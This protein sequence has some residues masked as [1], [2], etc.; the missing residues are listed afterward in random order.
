MTRPTPP[1]APRPATWRRYLRFWGPNVG[2]DVRDE[3]QFHIDMRTREFEA[4]G[5]DPQDARQA[6][7]ARFGDMAR[8]D[9]ALQ[10]HDRRVD[11]TASVRE[12]ATNVGADVRHAVRA[13]RRAPGFATAAILCLA[14]GT[15]ATA[16][17]FAVVDALLLQPLPVQH[18][19]NLVVIATTSSGM[20]LPGDD[21]YQNYLDIQGTHA[22]LE[23]AAASLTDAFNIRVGNQ[24]DLRTV[25]AVSENYWP[26]LGVRPVLGRTFTPEEARAR[27]PF[28]VIGYRYWQQAF[29]G[30]PDVVGRA[31]SV[32][33]I[34]LTIA[35]VA[36]RDFTGAH[37][38]IIPDLWVPVT[39]LYEIDPSTHDQMQRR[40]GGGF[41]IIGRLQKGVSLATAQSALNVLATHLQH[42]YPADDEGKRF[43][44][45]RELRARPDIAVSD[46][47]PRVAVV[48]MALTT[49]VLLI[50]C[51]NVASL[52][53]ARANGRRTELAVRSALSRR[54]ATSASTRRSRTHRAT[55]SAPCA[56]RHRKDQG[57]VPAAG[58]DLVICFRGGNYADRVLF[59]P[60]REFVPRDIL[61]AVARP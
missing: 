53:L 3:L 6:A 60:Q 16:T 57:R 24:T 21:S 36:P 50:A 49:L 35:G 29:G 22:V 41:R 9:A 45:Q 44:V 39:L 56:G 31:V 32:D 14:L 33:G 7:L 42:Q 28:A 2:A 52:M 40:A 8:V 47:V 5:M 58:L 13:L 30:A 4:R 37:P 11:R 1:A 19:G 27:A 18:P 34:P 38:M 43:V 26:M 61:P 23:D 25:Q 12:F 10:S 55:S 59:V 15:G 48:F 46:L 17:V 51:A 20:T 54:R